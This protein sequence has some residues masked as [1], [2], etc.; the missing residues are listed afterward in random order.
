MT[1]DAVNPLLPA[2]YDVV[3]TGATGLVIVFAIAALVS[4]GRAKD[5]TGWRALIW[6]LAVLC[7]PVAGATL[8]FAVGRPAKV[9]APRTA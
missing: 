7:L 5:V 8:W 4:I 1:P 9:S 3:W 2:W 6:I